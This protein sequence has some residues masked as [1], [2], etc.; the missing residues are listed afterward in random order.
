[1][2]QRREGALM[3]LGILYRMV[4]IVVVEQRNRLVRVIT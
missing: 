1:M 2:E 3:M 4:L